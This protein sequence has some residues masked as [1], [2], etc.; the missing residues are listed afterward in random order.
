MLGHSAR[1]F[2][3]MLPAASDCNDEAK[4]IIKRDIDDE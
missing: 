4:N 3:A 2:F 1:S